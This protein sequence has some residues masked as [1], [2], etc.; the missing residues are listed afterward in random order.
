MKDIW[1]YKIC[2]TFHFFAGTEVV[3]TLLKFIKHFFFVSVHLRKNSEGVGNLVNWIW[4]CVFVTL[5]KSSLEPR[6]G[7]NQGMHKSIG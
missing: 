5:L 4:I 7:R 6:R 2:T 3:G 1:M